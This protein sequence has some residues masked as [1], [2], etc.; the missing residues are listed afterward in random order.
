MAIGVDGQFLL[1]VTIGGNIDFLGREDF[2]GLTI[3]EEAGNVLPTFSLTFKSDNEKLIQSMNEGNQLEL[4]FGKTFDS[5]KDIQLTTT[6]LKLMK[7]GAE[8][9]IYEATGFCAEVDYVTEHELAVVS[10]KSGIEAVIET[11]GNFFAQVNA[12]I[13]KSNGKQSWIRHN[14]SGKAFVNKCA[15]HSDLGTSFPM[16]AITAENEFIL[17]DFETATAGG[18]LDYDWRF[19]KNLI[20]PA[21]DILFDS[22]Y[23][24]TSK[25]GFVNSWIGYGRE[26]IAY[27]VVSGESQIVFEQ[28]ET[29]LAL[30]KEL[31]KATSITERYGGTQILSDNVHENY[32]NAYN[33]NLI[34]L[35]NL[36]KIDCLL[37]FTDEYYEIKPLDLI[38]FNDK[39]TEETSA[40]GEYTS[41]LYLCSKVVRKIESD[42][43]LTTVML[44][45]EAFNSVKNG[46]PA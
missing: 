21:R 35:A 15:M 30:A 46:G 36:S 6:K 29:V 13:Q 23:L 26:T 14:I 16:I 8:F 19:T 22:D 32:W 43:L 37:S 3:V 25:A 40:A 1:Q 39:A 5:L 11:A 45:R 7:E 18:G 38:M 28:P 42:R 44:N 34:Q 17:K 12:N 27:D 10:Q 41:G 31:D 2:Y 9:R 24:H 4:K 33:H 20:D